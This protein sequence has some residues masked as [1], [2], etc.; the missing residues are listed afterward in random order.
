[1]KIGMLFACVM[2]AACGGSKTQPS[3]RPTQPAEP[4]PQASLPENR[5]EIYASRTPD[6][7]PASGDVGTEPA[8]T[9]PE[10][11][12]VTEVPIVA[13]TVATA[14]LV[15]ISG[16]KPMGTIT[17]TRGDDGMITITGEFAGLKKTSVHA[18][19]IHENGDCSNKGK[20]VGGHLNPTKVK[21]GPP[22]SSQRHAGDFGNLTADDA[23]NAVFTMTT[24]SVTM[25]A[26][27]PDSILNRSVVIHS[28]KDDKKGNAG[29]PL[30]CGVIVLAPA[31]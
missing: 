31:E 9:T 22:A 27:R 30:A 10:V 21:H 18:I 25:E 8:E 24:D 14:E 17:F 2:L 6:A 3:Q 16:G 5:D 4:Q 1:M 20:K 23:G 15:T 12:P 26:D 7:E 29:T 11:A 13:Q 28:K 19:Y